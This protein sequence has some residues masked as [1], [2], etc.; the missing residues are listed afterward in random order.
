[1]VYYTKKSAL[2]REATAI[3]LVISFIFFFSFFCTVANK[4]SLIV[5]LNRKIIE[6]FVKRHP[7]SPQQGIPPA[8]CLEI[9]LWN[10]LKDRERESENVFFFPPLKVA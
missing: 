10:K 3:F 6:M 2:Q 9:K 5:S 7:G 4:H 8:T 1:M